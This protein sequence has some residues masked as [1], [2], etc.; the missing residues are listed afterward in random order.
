M[1]ATYRSNKFYTRFLIIKFKNFLTLDFELK[2]NMFSKKVFKKWYIDVCF[3]HPV[4][5]KKYR[6]LYSY[7]IYNYRKV[8]LLSI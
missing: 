7:L 1:I 4:N 6:N 8:S 2:S 5:K 3:L